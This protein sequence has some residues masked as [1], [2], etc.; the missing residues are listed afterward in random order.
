MTNFNLE[1][2]EK[3]ILQKAQRRE[4]KRR[5]IMKVFGRNV[6][7]LAEIIKKKAQGQ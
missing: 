4:K 2:L 3:K 1:D 5:P 7:K 6:L